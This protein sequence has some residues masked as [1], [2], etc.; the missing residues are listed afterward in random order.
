MYQDIRAV[1]IEKR[2]IVIDRFWILSPAMGCTYSV[3]KW[4]LDLIFLNDKKWVVI[5]TSGARTET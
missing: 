5:D 3:R 1:T 2:I 4:I